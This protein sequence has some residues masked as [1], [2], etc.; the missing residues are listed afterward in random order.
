MK[1]YMHK[2]VAMQAVFTAF[3]TS[4]QKFLFFFKQGTTAF[5]NGMNISEVLES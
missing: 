1:M 2:T 4:C 3:F 5:S